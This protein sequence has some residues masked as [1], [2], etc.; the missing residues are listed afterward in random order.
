MSTAEFTTVLVAQEATLRQMGFHFT[1]NRDDLQDLIQDTLARALRYKDRFVDG[2]NLKSWLFVMMKN[3]YINQYNQNVGRKTFADGTPGEYYL[4]AHGANTESLTE[5]QLI[6]ADLQDS[7]S[8]LSEK[9]RT[10]FELHVEGYQY[11]E[12]ADELDIPIGTV[13]SRIF[14]ARERL[15]DMLADYSSWASKTTR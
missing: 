12:I 6:A 4:N 13:K 14:K 11:D 5:R 9:F 15:Q 1:H 8:K 7:I 10:P 2:T 3:I